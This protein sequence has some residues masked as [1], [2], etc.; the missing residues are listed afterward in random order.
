MIELSTR[1]VPHIVALVVI[2]T[3]PTLLHSLGRFDVDDCAAPELLLAPPARDRAPFLTTGERR[4]FD[5]F[6]GA[7]NWS[8]GTLPAAA[9]GGRLSYLIARSFDPKAV[10][11][12]PEARVISVR[13]GKRGLEEVES[14]GVRLPVHRA[15]YEPDG[16]SADV[17]LAAYLLIYD[18]RPVVNPY[19]AQILSGPRQVVTGRHPMWLFIVYGTVGEPERRDAEQRAHEWLASAWESHRAACA[20]GPP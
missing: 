11:H 8:A 6:W 14:Q 18:S 20:P 2:A 19:L 16:R 3:I 5:S 4:R 7:G 9:S 1:Y 10:Y 13:P 15:Y 17:A 12:W